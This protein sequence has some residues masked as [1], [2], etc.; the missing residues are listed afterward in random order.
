MT[1]IIFADPKKTN[2]YRPRLNLTT[3]EYGL[4]VYIAGELKMGVGQFI[5]ELLRDKIINPFISLEN[6]NKSLKKQIK[7]LKSKSVKYRVYA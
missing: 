7:E 1:H 2:T 4:L 6:E 5:S 3:D